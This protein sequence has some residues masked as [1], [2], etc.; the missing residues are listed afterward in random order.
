M[1]ADTQYVA[2]LRGINVGG[3]NIIRMTLLKECLQKTGLNDVATYIQSGNVLFSSREVKIDRLMQKM[4]QVLSNEFDYESR[5][6]VVSHQ[7]L[8]T[9]VN[10]APKGFG[11]G[12]DHYRYD[13]IFLRR[14]LTPARAMKTVKVRDGVDAAWKG[15]D[16]LYFSRLIARASQSYLSRIVGLPVYQNMTIRNW[17]TTTKLLALMDE[18]AKERTTA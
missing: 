12:P 4:E 18:R 2:L 10:R 13:V 17:N 16:V 7:M 15:K 11:T 1:I 3:K 14:P 9:A 5:V 8:R 6:V